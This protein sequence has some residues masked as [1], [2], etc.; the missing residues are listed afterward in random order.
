MKNIF[1]NDNYITNSQDLNFAVTLSWQFECKPLL[2]WDDA[3]I[4]ELHS[5]ENKLDKLHVGSDGA[6]FYWVDIHLLQ[7]RELRGK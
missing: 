6:G 2:R 5:C 1:E 4:V 7:P 3:I